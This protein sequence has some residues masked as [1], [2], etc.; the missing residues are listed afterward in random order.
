MVTHV[1]R[2]YTSYRVA[3]EMPLLLGDQ[4][5]VVGCPNY[6]GGNSSPCQRV[7]WTTASPFLIVRGQPALVQTSTGLCMAANG[8]PQGTAIIT[9]FQTMDAEPSD[10]TAVNY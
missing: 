7:E 10:V 9:S 3:G 8:A 2:T 6:Q 1:P 4:Y 5:I